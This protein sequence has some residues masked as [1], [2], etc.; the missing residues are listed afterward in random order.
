MDPGLA[1]FQLCG[2]NSII[3]GAF[4]AKSTIAGSGA[5]MVS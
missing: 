4:L 5:A 2:H 1:L 3:I